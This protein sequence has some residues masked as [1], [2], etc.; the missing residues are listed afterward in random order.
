MTTVTSPA[1]AIHATEAERH[2]L[3]AIA[4]DIV[5]DFSTRPAA[6]RK[7][8]AAFLERLISGTDADHTTLRGSL[9]IRG[10]EIVGRLRPLRRE[11]GDGSA[12]LLFWSCRFD[13]PVDL[14]GGDF[15]SLRF[16]DCTMPAFIGASLTTKADLDL[17]G[18]RFSGVDDYECELA[19]VGTCAIH[20]SNA[21]IGGRLAAGST[22]QARATMNG[23]VRLDGARV[24][25][26]VS[27]E[28]AFIDG[29][30]DAAVNARSMIVGGNVDF[31]WAG[32]H[33]FEALGEV[34]LAAARIV[35]DL[36]LSGAKLS[37]PAGRALHCEDLR[38]ESVFLGGDGDAP[39]EAAGRLNFLSA[40]IGGSFFMTSA[41]LAPGPD[42]NF[43]GRG[44]PVALN[45]QQ[46][47]V[48]NTIVMTNIGELDPNGPPP[49]R[50][51]P[52]APVKGWFLLN[53]AQLNGIIDNLDSGWPAHGYLD[54]DGAT[55]ERLGNTVGRDLV[56]GRIAW[57]RRQFPDG[58]PTADT[59]RPQPYEELSRVLRRHGQSQE[60][61]AIAV[62]KIRMRLTARIDRPWA[63]V[64]PNLLMLVSHHGYSTGRAML[65]FAIFV[66]F[67]ALMYSIAVWGFDQPFVPFEISPEPVEY[68]FPFDLARVK[69]ERGC[70]GLNVFEYALDVA[71]PFINLG[72]DTYCRFAPEGPWRG[73]W[74]LLHSLYV[75]VGTALSAVVVLTLTG[76]LRRD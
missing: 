28:G 41:R 12:T 75:L 16:V 51:T 68:V 62:E 66:L 3:D 44:R 33:R 46:L 50:S 76:V 21:R 42:M 58:H 49:L 22:A 30:G 59:F 60:A 23:V 56:A 15:L 63:R 27:L 72:Q 14:S 64:V 13:G 47:R 6:Q 2:L 20:L 43:L 24:D 19:D 70:P 4:S 69:S 29:R 57:L 73:I 52:A 25:G 7:L 37:N 40:T 35:G 45:L 17:S 10:A 26:D 65:C 1:A 11:H 54:L 74:S 36:F 18:S 71:L 55:Y 8:S 53:G 32:G 67:G 34:S 38:V 31:A 61:D 48:S 5:A 39:F 9:R